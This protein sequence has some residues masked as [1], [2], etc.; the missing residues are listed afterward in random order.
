MTN[1][2]PLVYRTI[3]PFVYINLN[4][5]NVDLKNLVAFLLKKQIK[6]SISIK[7]D[8]LRPTFFY[9]YSFRVGFGVTPKCSFNLFEISFTF[10]SFGM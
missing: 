8:W 6:Q 10:F 1:Y 4:D 7:K 3:T 2:S 5:L 9:T